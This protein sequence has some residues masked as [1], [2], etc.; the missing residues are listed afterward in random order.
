MSFSKEEIFSYIAILVIVV[1]LASIGT[2][3]TGRAT[4]V[5]TA[6]VN[7]TVITSAAINFSVA[8]IEFGSGVVENLTAGAT[9]ETD[10]SVQQGNWSGTQDPLT[11]ENIGNVNITLNLTSDVDAASFLGGLSPTFEYQVTNIDTDACVGNA[12][13]SWVEFGTGVGIVVCNPLE[14]NNSK[15]EIDIHIKLYVPS[16]SKTGDRTATIT[17]TGEYS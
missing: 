9:L 15:D 5:D 17:A 12:A 7:L 11:L 2:Q 1:S 8:L 4:A 3:L 16:D 10:Q 13:T 6:I 14:F